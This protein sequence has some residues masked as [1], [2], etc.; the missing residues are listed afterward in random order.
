MYQ[1]EASK[2]EHYTVARKVICD[3]FGLCLV[4]RFPWTDYKGRKGKLIFLNCLIGQ[5]LVLT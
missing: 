5:A 4:F 1:D 2:C 3:S